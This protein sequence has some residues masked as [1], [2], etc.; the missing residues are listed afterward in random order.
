LRIVFPDGVADTAVAAGGQRIIW[1]TAFVFVAMITLLGGYLL[2]R[3]MRRESHIA[4][5]RTQFV[6]SVSHELKTPL[7]SI[8]MFAELLQMKESPDPE[9]SVFLATIVSESERLTRLL[10][11]V[12]DFSRVERGQ[13]TYHLQPGAISEVVE[14]AVRTI[15][16]PL[17]QQGFSLDL[18]VADG[19]PPAEIDRDAPAGHSQP[20]HQCHEILR[21]KPGNQPPCNGEKRI[22]AD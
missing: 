19:M 2:W 9:Q 13:K 21:A 1:T 11:N 3:D 7:T 16:Y 20:A 8:R 15:Q 14:A 17:S 5:L 10:N 22:R 12:L 6:S 4:E 18:Q